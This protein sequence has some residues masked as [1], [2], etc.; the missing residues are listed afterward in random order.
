MLEEAN[1]NNTVVEEIN[2]N[3]DIN[4]TVVAEFIDYNV[5]FDAYQTLEDIHNGDDLDTFDN[6]NDNATVDVNAE[7][8]VGNVDNDQH[9]RPVVLLPWLLCLRF[10]LWLQ[11]YC[12]L[13]INQLLLKLLKM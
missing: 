8:N 1:V 4:P 3:D 10:Q 2:G 11:L 7:K 12:P 9:D 13:H 6:L 5:V